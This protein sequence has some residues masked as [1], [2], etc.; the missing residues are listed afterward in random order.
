MVQL[1][2]ILGALVV[3]LL[4]QLVALML[5]LRRYANK[6]TPQ[7]R[8]E[9]VNGGHSPSAPVPGEVLSQRVYL[10]P[11]EPL[12]RRDYPPPMPDIPSYEEVRPA[13]EESAQQ[14]DEA[15]FRLVFEDN[16]RLHEQLA[17]TGRE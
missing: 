14:Q 10:D 13:E 15:V 1:V 8:L 6:L 2:S 7:V 12:P 3:M 9:V 11:G 4:V 17:A 5:I 16:L